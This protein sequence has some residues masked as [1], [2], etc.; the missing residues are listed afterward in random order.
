LEIRQL[1]DRNSVHHTVSL[2]AGAQSGPGQQPP[3]LRGPYLTEGVAPGS[4]PLGAGETGGKLHGAL[5]ELCHGL[6]LC[7]PGDESSLGYL[8]EVVIQSYQ[9]FGLGFLS[10]ELARWVAGPT[11][12]VVFQGIQRLFFAECGQ[13]SD[14]P[15]PC[16][17]RRREGVFD[18]LCERLLLAQSGMP[19]VAIPILPF[20]GKLAKETGRTRSLGKAIGCAPMVPTILPYT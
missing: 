1:A 5:R 12:Q 14:K 3:S 10:R 7:D 19:T 20:S 2:G 6:S 8:P 17:L 13:D 11:G 15:M 4:G 9:P 16:P 18:S